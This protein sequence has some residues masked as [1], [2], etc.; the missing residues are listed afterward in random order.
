MHGRDMCEENETI[1]KELKKLEE[2]VANLEKYKRPIESSFSAPYLENGQFLSTSPPRRSTI[3]WDYVKQ[4]VITMGF[5]L[6]ILIAW[7][8]VFLLFR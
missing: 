2:R 8:V 3:D 1:E 4:R 5:W 7:G 6:A